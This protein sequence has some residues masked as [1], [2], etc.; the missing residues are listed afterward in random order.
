MPRTPGMARTGIG[1]S[2]SASTRTKVLDRDL[3]IW[4]MTKKVYR[5]EGG[6][7]GL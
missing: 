3:G 6:L 2:A 7:K 1:S 4:G 5:T